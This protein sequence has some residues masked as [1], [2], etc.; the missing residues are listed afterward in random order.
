MRAIPL[1]RR[2]SLLR[3]SKNFFASKNPLFFEKYPSSSKIPLFF[4]NLPSSKKT[5]FLVER[6][7][8][9]K[10]LT[11]LFRSRKP[12][13]RPFLNFI[14]RFFGYS[15]DGKGLQNQRSA[16]LLAGFQERRALF[17]P[18]VNRWFCASAG[19]HRDSFVLVC[20]GICRGIP[21]MQ[22]RRCTSLHPVR[23]QE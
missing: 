9:F 5:I 1:L 14:I 17:V 6:S 11:L 12:K 13:N 18:V 3:T 15:W 8:V 19:L 23:I 10:E 21:S 4:E 22:K 20:T 2:T 16:G 7:L